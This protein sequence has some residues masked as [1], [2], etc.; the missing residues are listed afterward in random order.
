MCGLVLLDVV[1]ALPDLGVEA[2]LLELGFTV[3]GWTLFVEL[4]IEMLK[5]ESVL[6][7]VDITGGVAL[8]EGHGGG[9]DGDGDGRSNGEDGETHIEF[10]L[11]CEK[12]WGLSCADGMEKRRDEE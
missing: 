8:G 9:H 6:E 12:I 2:G 11:E 1:E 5:G 7:D 4:S 10:M 3:L